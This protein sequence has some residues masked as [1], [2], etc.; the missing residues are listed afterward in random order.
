M[1][2][3]NVALLPQGNS[4]EALLHAVAADL[5]RA[6]E[7]IRLGLPATVIK[8]TSAYFNVSTSRIRAIVRL[9]ETTA[10]TLVKR[11]ANIDAAASERIW[12]LADLLTMASDVFEDEE[13]AKT[14]LRMPNRAFGDLAP[15][16]YL[17]TEPGAMAVRQ[18]LN[19]IGT[20]GT[21]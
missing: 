8:D 13:A 7:A 14:W 17:D 2:S 12:R 10:H 6:I 21:A 1:T 4:F 11:G 19:A 9:P 16:E 15:M 18:V 20:G 3:K 5:P